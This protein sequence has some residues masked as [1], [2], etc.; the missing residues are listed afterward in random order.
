MTLGRTKRGQ[1]GGSR[2]PWQ[3]LRDAVAGDEASARLWQ[4]DALVMHGR[5]QQ[6]WSDGLKR[7][8]GVEEVEDEEAAEGEEYTEEE[9]ET[10][11]SWSAAEWRRIRHRR[12]AVLS[13]AERGGAPEVR[14]VLSDD[15]SPPA[16]ADP[17]P[18]PAEGDEIA[19]LLEGLDDPPPADLRARA[20]GPRQAPLEA[21]P[22]R[23]K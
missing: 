4:G 3:I 1:V 8:C 12:A 14:R 22:G 13:A 20:R 10:V 9:D 18:R 16:S 23:A 15:E 5:R 2:S 7:A 17:P 6:G 11:A 21:A 19:E